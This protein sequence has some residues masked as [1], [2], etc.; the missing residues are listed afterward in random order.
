MTEATKRRLPRPTAFG[1]VGVAVVVLVALWFVVSNITASNDSQRAARAA[2]AIRADLAS[3]TVLESAGVDPTDFESELVEVEAVLWRR[4]D[5]AVA[6]IGDAEEALLRSLVTE[7]L[8]A[9]RSVEPTPAE[10]TDLIDRKFAALADDAGDRADAAASNTIRA[11][12]LTGVLALVALLAAVSLTGRFRARRADSVARTT[13]EDRHRALLEN[14]PLLVYVIGGDGTLEYASPRAQASYGR[15]TARVESLA[16]QLAPEH[17]EFAR[18]LID[19][20]VE[21]DVPHIVQ[22]AAGSWFEVV[23]SDHRGHPSIDGL[24]VTARDVSERVELEAL[25]RREATED[26]L[27]GTT[28]RRGL[29]RALNAA[30]RSAESADATLAVL[31]IDLDGFKQI[32]DMLGHGSGDDVLSQVGERLRGLVRGTEQVARYGG[33]EF[34]VIVQGVPSRAEVEAVAAR[35][36]EALRVPYVVEGEIITL[37]ASIGIALGTGGVEPSDLLGFADRAMYAAK[38]AG[39]GCWCWA[40][41]TT[42]SSTPRH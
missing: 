42:S 28:N 7:R 10:V 18:S 37:G 27:T 35:L 30:V 16:A 21:C 4:L 39:G 23:V 2:T 3:I 19:Q 25:L 40:D 32:N 38:A 11:A 12:Y 26:S 8:D 1:P 15:I 5:I 17:A 33:D 14:A 6:D 24:V 20:T 9:A 31:L 41:Q 34:A 36:L 22:S 13:A 29:D